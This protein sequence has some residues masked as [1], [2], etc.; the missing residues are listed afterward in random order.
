M[1]RFFPGQLRQLILLRFLVFTFF[2]LVIENAVFGLTWSRS[3]PLPDGSVS[4]FFLILCLLSLL[5]LYWLKSG[6]KL[7]LLT[8]LQCALDPVLITFLIVGTGGLESPFYFL[9]GIAILNTAFL[10]GPREAF[11]MAGVI[12]IYSVGLVT[13]ISSLNIFSFTPKIDQINRLVF[14]GIAFLLTALLAGA[15]SRR[16]KGIQQ[17]L[18]QQTDSLVDLA[19]LH[20]QIVQTLPHALIST[21]LGGLIIGVNPRAESILNVNAAAIQGQPLKNHFPGFQWAIDQHVEKDTYL[22]FKEGEQ[23]L[24]VNVSPLIN[25]YQKQIGSLLFIRDLTNIK[26]L[27]Q[28][29]SS[30]DKL[31]LTGQM[32]AGVAHEIR[33][34]L[35]SILSA[36]QM[37][38]EDQSRDQKLKRIIIEEVGRLKQLT[39]DFLFFS[40]PVRPNQ[41]SV[42]L[43]QFLTELT[44]QIQSDPRWGQQRVLH[45]SIPQQATIFF[46][47]N[48]LRQIFWNL[49]INAIQASPAG[50][51]ISLTYHSR[52][53]L[54]KP[55]IIIED[56]GPGLS[57]EEISKVLE[58]FYTTR[59]DGTGLGLAV[60]AQL[61][62]LNGGDIHLKPGLE[63]GLQIL[64]TVENEHG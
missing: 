32:A 7:F 1:G 46:D 61:V 63:K 8:R 35:A 2:I 14:Q 50:G 30:R 51:T 11:I 23:I 37:F 25:P 21:D 39:T 5:Y 26:K 34:P 52:F 64:L 18:V 4:L 58:P 6:K 33:N 29:L 28:K 20:H 16:I 40:K 60:V 38:S 44:D 15:L 43:L 57:G 41:Q 24:G 19:T 55:T 59:S 27:E 48:H 22:E 45:F 3:I 47:P 31:S 54:G 49:L 9:F 13:L 62:R 10:L 12:L 17:A 56:D 42:V 36:A 53:H